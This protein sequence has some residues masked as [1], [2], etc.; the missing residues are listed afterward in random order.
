MSS[1][2]CISE[3]EVKQIIKKV[4]ADKASDISDILNKVLQTDLAKLISILTSLFNI[5]VIHKYYLKQFKKTQMIV[6]CKLKKS[7]YT[8]SKTYQLIALLD[9]MSKA[10]KSIMTKRLSDIT[11]THHML[12][13]AQMRARRKR[14]VISTLNLLVDQIHTIW[15]CEI[16]YITFML[17]LNI[18]KAFNQV[19]HIRLLH[20]LKMKRTSNYTVE[21][22]CSFLENRET[23]LKF[24]EQMSD[25]H[26]I[27]ANISQKFLISSILFL[28]FNASLIEKC[29]VLRIKIKVLNFINNI[30]ILTYNK[31]I[32]EIC[33]TLSRMHDVCAKWVC[34]HDITFASEKYELTHFIRK[35]KEFDMMI[36]IQIE[37][38]VIK[39]K[40]DVQVLKVQ[41]NMK[42]WW[43]AHLRQIEAN[44]V[45]WMLALNWLEVFTWETIFTKARQIYSAVVRSEIAFEAS[46][47]HQREKEK[48]LSG[49]ECRLETLQNQILHHVAK[50]FKRVRIETLKAEMYTSSLH[51]HLNMLQD[52]IT[53]HS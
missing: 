28:F 3:N 48:K 52:K 16:K 36:S 9:I 39:L 15:D 51:V 47:W 11:E 2:S 41:L 7:D 45:T 31:F 4:K 17:S 53:L 6:L 37:N 8:D 35:S 22:A 38:L 1:D 25:M 10:L 44:H 24:N 50:A 33:R 34:T 32:E 40:S 20:T 49:K 18:V 26:K 5:C 30:N 19:L 29:K 27:Y 46:V 21:W 12:S 13:D 43:S 23:L 14:F 42:L